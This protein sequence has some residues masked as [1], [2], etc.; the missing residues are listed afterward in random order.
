[1]TYFN[2][3]RKSRTN[4]QLPKKQADFFDTSAN[5]YKK[6]TGPADA[7]FFYII[8]NIFQKFIIPGCFASLVA[9]HFQFKPLTVIHQPSH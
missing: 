8:H 4:D 1:K 6:P 7:H 9:P 5:A 2:Q 3:Y